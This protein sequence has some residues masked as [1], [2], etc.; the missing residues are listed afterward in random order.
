MWH[1][2]LLLALV[3]LGLELLVG[4]FVLLS[5]AIA[6]AITAIANARYAVEG[7][8]NLALLFAVSAVISGY[9]LRRWLGP[10][11]FRRHD[12]NKY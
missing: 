5:F 2:L 3:C 7:I 1:L 9:A 6:F 11:M 12:V 8:A 4:T 10:R